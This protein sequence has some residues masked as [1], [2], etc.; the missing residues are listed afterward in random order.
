LGLL[1]TQGI[2]A[3]HGH[4]VG[5]VAQSGQ[6]DRRGNWCVSAE[7]AT[8][9]ADLITHHGSA[10]H[11]QGGAVQV[12]LAPQGDTT[13]GGG[14]HDLYVGIDNART[15]TVAGCG[16][17]DAVEADGH[18]GNGCAPGGGGI[19]NGSALIGQGVQNTGYRGGNR[20]SVIKTNLHNG[21]CIHGT[22]QQLAGQYGWGGDRVQGQNRGSNRRG[23]AAGGRQGQLCFKSG[24]LVNAMGNE[25]LGMIKGRP[26]ILDPLVGQGFQELH[27]F[28][29]PGRFVS[30]V[31]DGL[32]EGG[33]L[34][35]AGKIP[36]AGIE[37]H[38][39]IQGQGRA[40]MEVG[41]SQLHVAQAGGFKGT[42]DDI[43]CAGSHQRRHRGCG[44]GQSGQARQPGK[45]KREGKIRLTGAPCQVF[46]RR[47]DTEIGKTAVGHRQGKGVQVHLLFNQGV[48]GIAGEH[49]WIAVRKCAGRNA[50]A[51]D[52][53]RGELSTG[54]AG[55]ASVVKS[56]ESPLGSGAQGI[57][58]TGAEAVKG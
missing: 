35:V 32:H 47:P 46:K 45:G 31:A 55:C 54:M 28:E 24:K 19:G 42:A 57:L 21:G 2:L 52:C 12:G 48:G 17:R 38:H 3:E 36:A 13:Q 37:F 30:Q 39:L 22:A 10:P 41:W 1:V 16:D 56:R 6:N 43:R 53:R 51:A 29:T 26:F 9:H 33:T 49:P 11:R 44:K 7:W 4:G 15:A 25:Q 40:V 18:A 8:V 14:R 27:H 23:R 5:C 58:I 20:R 34:R 50:V